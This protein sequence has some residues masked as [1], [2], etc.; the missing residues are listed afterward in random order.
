MIIRMLMVLI[1]ATAVN[2]SEFI[3]NW[4]PGKVE[5]LSYEIR[6]FQ[7]SETVSHTDLKIT[8]TE[9]KAPIFIV[10]QKLMIPDQSI[11][12][13]ST[14]TYGGE[15]LQIVSSENSFKLPDKAAE[16]LEVDTLVVKAKADLGKLTIN[17]NSRRLPRSILPLTAP[18]TTTVGFRLVSRNMDFKIGNTRDYEF[19][20]LLTLID[21]ISKAPE[22]RDSIVGIENVRT[23]A[24]TF[25][26]YK[27]KNMV[28]GSESYNYYTTDA[29]HIPVK[30]EIIDPKSGQPT[31]T[32]ILQKYE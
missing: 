5:K 11:E 13:Y 12:M 29:R 18:L 22:A 6:T 1:L 17:F 4:E 14:E 2:A 10:E 30:T 24:G 9:D 3:D 20:N 19:I 8:R 31:M 15:V 28:T 23:P 16:Q 25:D 26:C 27:V 32:L 21:T 7:P